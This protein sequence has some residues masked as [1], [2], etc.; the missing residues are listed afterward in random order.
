MSAVRLPGRLLD[1]LGNYL[2]SRKGQESE[3]IPADTQYVGTG[4]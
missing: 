1:P 2:V 3:W 4:T